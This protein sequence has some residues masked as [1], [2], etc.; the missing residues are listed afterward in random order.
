MKKFIVSF[1]C[2]EWDNGYTSANVC[3]TNT[4]D[5]ANFLKEKFEECIKEYNACVDKNRENKVIGPI[6]KERIVQL[7]K[8]KD[9]KYHAIFLDIYLGLH[10]YYNVYKGYFN[11]EEIEYIEE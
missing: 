3:I 11:V 10:Y 7:L 2:E 9:S 1:H 6:E 4:L 5:K 8:Q